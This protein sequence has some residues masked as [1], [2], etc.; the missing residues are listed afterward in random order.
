[1][2]LD[3]FKINQQAPLRDALEKI[4]VNQHGLI[5]VVDDEDCVVGLASDGDI[6]SKLLEGLSLDDVISLCMNLILRLLEL[7]NLARYRH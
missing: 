2:N 3:K 1:M 5:I 6:R 7:L 4:R